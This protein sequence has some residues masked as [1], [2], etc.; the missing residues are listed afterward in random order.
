MA[1]LPPHTITC[2]EWLP[3]CRRGARLVEFIRWR[4]L[5]FPCRTTTGLSSKG[6]AALD[7]PA[8]AHNPPFNDSRKRLENADTI[9]QA[10][11]EA[12]GKFTLARHAT[13]RLGRRNRDVLIGELDLSNDELA[14]ASITL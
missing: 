13:P 5:H 14:A 8:P 11:Q 7:V 12:V 2:A 1:D 9:E 3:I 4:A 10:L 6:C